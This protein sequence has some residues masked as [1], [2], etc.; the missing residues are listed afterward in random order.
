MQPSILDRMPAIGGILALALATATVLVAAHNRTLQETANAGQA[1]LANAQAAGNLNNTLIRLLATAA[2]E[3]N[4]A[5]IK[6]L[7]TAN[8]VTYREGPAPTPTPGAGTQG[9]AK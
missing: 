7:L 4:D 5:D 9:A 8:G 2:V 1:K 3:H 6:S